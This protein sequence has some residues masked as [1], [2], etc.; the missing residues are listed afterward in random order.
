MLTDSPPDTG[1]W[2]EGESADRK[3]ATRTVTRTVMFTDIADYTAS[4]A[5]TDR[6]GLHQILA[7]HE[8]RVKP[9]VEEYAGRI[10]KN[11][12][13]SFLCLF[14]SATDALRAALDIQNHNVN[15]SVRVRIGLT[16]GDIEMIDGDAFGDAVN[17]AA[18][19]LAKAPVGEAWFGACTKLAMN[20]AEIPWESVGWFRLKGIPGEQECF[21]VVPRHRVWLPHAVVGANDDSSLVRIHAGNDVPNIPPDPTILFEG[22]D[23]GSQALTDT[24]DALPVLDPASL[25]LVTYQIPDHD[26]QMWSECGRG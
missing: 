23:A 10:V 5:R 2:A 22:F 7:E 17:L 11:I 8:N 12:G 25:Y 16:T 26:R 20:A 3:T 21:R 9:V 19:I 1:H 4:V 15:G 14:D 24:L 18:R 13:D 6:E